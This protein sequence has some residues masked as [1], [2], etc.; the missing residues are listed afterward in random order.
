MN[1]LQLRHFQKQLETIINDT[2]I[3]NDLLVNGYKPLYDGLSCI[4][5][6]CKSELKILW[7]L[8]EAY[9]KNYN[10][11][12]SITEVLFKEYPYDTKIKNRTHQKMAYLS[13]G[14]LNKCKY[15]D[16]DYLSSNPCVGEVLHKIAYINLNKMP[17]NTFTNDGTLWGKYSIWKD[18]LWSQ[19]NNYNPNVI[20]F[21]NTFRYFKDDFFKDG[22]IECDYNYTNRISTKTRANIYNWNKTVLIDTN[23]PQWSACQADWA[24]AI[25]NA[26]MD[27]CNY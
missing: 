25:V 16:I 12:W 2:A 22:I 24:N 15:E 7:I 10:G 18:V 6:Y 1:V 14:I 20:I 13:Y 8:K 3:K 5:E 19:I 17:A 26:C 21:G 4:E 9:D 23:H 27:Y 11:G